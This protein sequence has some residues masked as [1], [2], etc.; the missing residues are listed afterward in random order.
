M[1]SPEPMSPR[2]VEYTP[3]FQLGQLITPGENRSRMVP[4]DAQGNPIMPFGKKPMTAE[5]G[6]YVHGDI[7]ARVLEPLPGADQTAELRRR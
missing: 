3:P 2:M 4:A 7:F 1:S 6:G 5:Q